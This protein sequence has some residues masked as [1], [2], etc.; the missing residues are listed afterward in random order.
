M[1]DRTTVWFSSFA[2]FIAAGFHIVAPTAMAAESGMLLTGKA[3]M[4]DWKSDAPG[5]R[6]KITAE[7]LPPPSSNILSIN[8]ARIV[9]R[10]A[11]TLLRVPPGFKIE[12][13]AEGL[14]DPRFLV[15]APNGDIFVVESRANQIKVLRDTNGDG[16]PDATE[17][18][19][20]RDLNKPF[21]IAFYPPGDDPQFLYVA[22]TDGVI[23]FPYRNGDLKARGPAEQLAARLSGGAARLRSGG[24]WTRDIVFSPDG[25]KMY[26]S[27]GS[28]SN[29]SDN[30][31]EADRA[32]IFEFNPDGTN[33]KV[34]A[35]GIRNAVGIAFRPGSNELWMSTNERDEIGE[36]LPPDY[37]S[38]VRPDGFYGWPW[39]YIGNHQD[40]R[41][42][43]KHPELADKV[44]IPDVLV[45]AHSASLNL[46]FYNGDQ[47]PS[48]Y[49]GDIFAAFHGSWNRMKRTGCKV[50]RVPFDHSTGKSLGEY[51][52]FVTG[53]VSPDGKVW[54]RPVGITVAKD[55]SLLI[56][57]DG[58]G[59]IW[60]VSYA[61]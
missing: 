3:A 53:F 16:K 40:P 43:G 59:T 34:Y 13:Y 27:I 35:W 1:R 29:V 10:P 11:G 5:V 58:N 48:E 24:H 44:I 51:Q 8:R 61:R 20:E 46:C 37:I 23:R 49:K 41:H 47:F 15:T 33:R 18:F 39:F 28:R 12:L 45:E 6:R 30:A 42:K 26:V 25:K 17:T 22:N 7:D 52:D 55:G 54:G 21:G 4:G 32:R 50:V 57:E 2:M 36:D 56:S 9:N 14:R 19:A 31:A 38:S 60:R